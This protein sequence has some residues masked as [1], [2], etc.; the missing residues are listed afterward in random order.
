MDI[1]DVK[2]VKE[3]LLENKLTQQEIGDLFGVSRGLIS[4]IARNKQYADIEPRLQ[5]VKIAGGQQKHLNLETQNVALVGQI[6]NLRQERN[7]LKRQLRAASKRIALVDGIVEQLSPII[8]PIK[9]AKPVQVATT[10]PKT[11]EESMV[12]LFSDNHCDQI[13][14]PSEVDG[15]EDYNFPVSARRHEVLAEEIIKWKERALTNF[16]FKRLHIFGLGDYTSGEIHGHEKKSYFGCRFTNDIA[17]AEMFA[18]FVREMAA[19]F[20]E[21]QIDTVIGNHG[22]L[23]DK[24]EFDHEAVQNNHD[25]LIMKMV[26]MLCR[27]MKNVKFNFPLGLSTIVE[28]EGFNF[29]LHHGHGKKGGA[30]VWNQARRKAAK[31]MPLHRG[32]LDYFCSGHFHSQGEAPASGGVRMIANGSFLDCD[33]YSYQSLDE[34]SSATQLLFGVHKNNGTSWRLPIQVRTADEGEG[35]Q[36]YQ[37]M[38]KP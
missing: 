7:L 13:V 32:K 15:L 27:D 10:G 23:N 5:A 14:R 3:L 36:R 30:E 37:I 38:E 22:R 2:K 12:L 31:V 8:K 29:F 16:N 33:P 4:N 9:P 11:I 18:Q 26:E 19:H 24:Y 28:V 1:K 25:T 35:P 17:I 6:E 34:A 21:V 20:P